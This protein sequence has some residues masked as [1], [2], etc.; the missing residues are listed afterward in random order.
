MRPTI[1]PAAV[2]RQVTRSLCLCF[3]LCVLFENSQLTELEQYDSNQSPP[4]PRFS[5]RRRTPP[6]HAA[7]PHCATALALRSFPSRRSHWPPP[8]T[9]HP[10]PSPPCR[11]V[12][13]VDVVVL[14]SSQGDSTFQVSMVQHIKREHPGLDVICGNVV[15]SWQARAVADLSRAAAGGGAWRASPQQQAAC[16]A[17]WLRHRRDRL[18]VLL[19][20][21]LCCFCCFSSQ[22]AAQVSHF[23]SFPFCSLP[24]LASR[25]QLSPLPPPPLPPP[26][27]L[28]RRRGG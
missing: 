4:A 26:A 1:R 15:T 19:C 3:C 13:H 18:P 24:C 20:V 7:A 16:A 10:H 11:D 27:V 22:D 23:L 25:N 21:F 12:G 17:S 14:D 28:P 6:P 8:S 2:S 5:H 9:H